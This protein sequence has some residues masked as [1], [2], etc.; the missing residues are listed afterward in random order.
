MD[1]PASKLLYV[2]GS[3][4]THGASV[5]FND[6]EKTAIFFT[7]YYPLWLSYIGLTLVIYIINIDGQRWIKCVGTI[8]K[9]YSKS[10]T[11][12]CISHIGTMYDLHE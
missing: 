4:Y 6:G 8:C 2:V 3:K 1:I 9:S 10:T 5:F 11:S 12:M 7:V